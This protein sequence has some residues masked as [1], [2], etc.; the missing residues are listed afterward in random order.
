MKTAEALKTA[1]WA[2][3]GAALFGSGMFLGFVSALVQRGETDES[4]PEGGPA[5]A[6]F[7]SLGGGYSKRI[8]ELAGAVGDLRRR[9][10]AVSPRPPGAVGDRDSVTL[11]VEQLEKR[12]EQLAQQAPGRPQVD[13]ILEAVEHMVA[14]RVAGLDERLAEQLQA[15]ELLRNASAQT[16]A[17]LQKLI[18][19]VDA[20]ADQ[21]AEAAE[22]AEAGASAGE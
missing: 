9:V 17:L 18:Q 5:P 2:V 11:R 4:A 22:P 16:D 20:L 6:P 8:D 21:A 3:A 12:V 1:T 15:I 14:V 13:E 10:D 19:A 7:P